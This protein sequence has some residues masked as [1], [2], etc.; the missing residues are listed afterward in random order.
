MVRELK[1]P[2]HITGFWVPY[3]TSDPITTGSLGVGLTLEPSV[4]SK[5]FNEKTLKLNSVEV[6]QDLK[7]VMESLTGVKDLGASVESPVGLG[8]GFGLS[9]A[10]SITLATSALIKKKIPITLKNVGVLAHI[11]E[12]TLRT[13]LGDVIA[14]LIGGGLVVRLKPG[15]PGVGEV[16]V[17]PINED[18]AVCAGLVGRSLTT[19]DMLKI[20]ASKIR[21]Y[22]LE[23]YMKFLK[24]PSL[25]TF[26][27]QAHEF[28]V[29]TGMLESALKERVDNLL[30]T[31]LSKGVVLG[32][33]VKKNTIAV[34]TQVNYVNEVYEVLKKVSKPL[35]VFGI[36]R[37]G[38][39]FTS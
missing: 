23:S 3:Y 17:L 31:L 15:P 1:I 34:L 39:L 25:D 9:A 5:N 21:K 33:F 4:K 30:R 32:Y 26:I 22:G 2:L 20:Y 19:P 35:G 27:E 14:E 7:Q 18:L 29:K 38:T 6:G 37:H 16:D 36:C 8:Q 12:V 11:T 24:N 13:G 10:L 28:S